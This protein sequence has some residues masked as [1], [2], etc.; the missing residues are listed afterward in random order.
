MDY[1]KACIILGVTE[2]DTVETIRKKYLKLIAKYHPD[3]NQ[4]SD[5][6]KKAQ[7]INQAYDYLKENYENR[8]TENETKTYSSTSYYQSSYGSNAQSS[9]Y[10]Q[11]NEVLITNN[12]MKMIMNIVDIM[13]N[14]VNIIRSIN[15]I[16][17]TMAFVQNIK[18]TKQLKNT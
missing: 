7:E 16:N 12:I 13:M 3:I 11:Y 9:N 5:A 18:I 17:H 15:V 2:S 1:N 14:L 6:T 4:S 8:S 10:Q